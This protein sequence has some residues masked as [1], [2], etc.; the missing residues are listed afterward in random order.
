MFIA[1]RR[2]SAPPPL[3]AFA[4]IAEDAIAGVLRL[5]HE[6]RVATAER[7]L[8]PDAI[9]GEIQ[10]RMTRAGA[11]I[12]RIEVACAAARDA[13]A[14]CREIDRCAW[15]PDVARIPAVFRNRDL[16]LA[17]AVYLSAITEYLE[18]GG[19]SRGSY[20]V[21]D[22]K[23]EFALNPPGAF[24]DQHILEMFVDQDLD[25]RKAWVPIRPIPQNDT[26]FETAWKSYRD[27]TVFD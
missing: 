11:H 21:V 26:W 27:G 15:A 13:W 24:V 5:A 23:G 16:C 14:L 4:A 2:R 6:V 3:A 18:R 17:H 25:V 22:A 10:Q 12:R 19:Q 8:V 1:H 9:R 20:L 7:R